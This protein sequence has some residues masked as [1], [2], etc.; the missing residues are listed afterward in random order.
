MFNITNN[1]QSVRMNIYLF[2]SVTDA[3]FRKVFN[4]VLS[5]RKNVSE[6]TSNFKYHAKKTKKKEKRKKVVPKTKLGIPKEKW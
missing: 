1:C 4:K 3:Q 6:D 5:L 2:L